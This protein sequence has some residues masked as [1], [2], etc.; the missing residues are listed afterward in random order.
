MSFNANL[1]RM[2]RYNYGKAINDRDIGRA[3]AFTLWG[4]IMPAIALALF[5]GKMPKKDEYGEVTLFDWAKWVGGTSTT[6]YL[7]SFVGV[8]D[9]ISPLSGYG[10]TLTPVGTGLGNLATFINNTYKAMTKEGYI[11]EKW[12]ALGKSAVKALEFGLATP[13]YETN[14]Q[15]KEIYDV[16]TDEKDFEPRKLLF[17]I[18]Y[19]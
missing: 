14:R 12:P 4:I 6:Y 15:L 5:K 13:L 8:R 9:I 1:F 19:R 17:N 18:P 10:Y 11:E 3:V 16:M 2:A 7:G